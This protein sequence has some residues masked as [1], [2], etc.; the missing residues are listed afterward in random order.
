MKSIIIR[1]AAIILAIAGIIGCS[2][3]DHD[4]DDFNSVP[5]EVRNDFKKRFPAATKIEW[6]FYS[7]S[8]KA[9]FYMENTEYEALWQKASTWEWARTEKDI[10]IVKTPLP[11]AVQNYVNSEYA[12][13]KIDDVDLVQVPGDEFYEI[14]MEMS[15]KPDTIIFIH[16]DGTL[17]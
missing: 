3:D 6:E 10:D 12:G 14:T 11:S 7:N 9:D 1:T 13:W 17:V 8:I 2:K 5:E 15:G 16:A 4:T